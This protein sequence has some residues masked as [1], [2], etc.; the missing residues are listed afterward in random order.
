[1]LRNTL[2]SCMHLMLCTA[3]FTQTS[4]L[5]QGLPCQLQQLPC[6]AVPGEMYCRRPFR[7]ARS[8]AQVWCNFVSHLLG[9]YASPLT[10][11]SQATLPDVQIKL[12]NDSLEPSQ[13][14]F[15]INTYGETFSTEQNLFII[16][17]SDLQV[18]STRNDST[19]VFTKRHLFQ[20]YQ[21]CI[22]TAASLANVTSIGFSSNTDNVSFCVEDFHMLPSQVASSG[23]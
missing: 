19:G 8:D 17:G 2:Q 3:C 6:T 23:K 7:H 14:N 13:C 12:G 5:W 1:M 22:P 11:P 9:G 21:A 4:Q 20:C 16:Y 10:V 18:N 15:G